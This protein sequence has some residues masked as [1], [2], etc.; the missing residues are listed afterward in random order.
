[1]LLELAVLE[2][3]EAVLLGLVKAWWDTLVV[4][5]H[6]EQEVLSVF[7]QQVALGLLVRE[8]LLTEE[9]TLDLLTLEVAG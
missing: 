5:E 7:M 2:A 8:M 9:R 1:V 6:K 3:L 4:L